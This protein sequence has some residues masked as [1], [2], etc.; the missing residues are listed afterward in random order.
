MKFSVCD[1]IIYMIG[2]TTL[3]A[4]FKPTP[5]Y[6]GVVLGTVMYFIVLYLSRRKS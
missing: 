4:C 2:F 5:P 1:L 6:L 3:S